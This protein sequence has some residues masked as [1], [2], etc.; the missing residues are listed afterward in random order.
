[1]SLPYR[2]KPLW[3]SKDR[4]RARWHRRRPRRTLFDH[5]S[6]ILLVISACIYA[7]AAPSIGDAMTFSLT[8]ETALAGTSLAR[9]QMLAPIPMKLETI[10]PS[11][12]KLTAERVSA[13]EPGPVPPEIA[14]FRNAPSRKLQ[15]PALPGD[16]ATGWR[17]RVIA[18]AYRF[19][20]VPY[21][22][23]GTDPNGFDCSGLI[24]YVMAR[25]GI[26]L[27]RTMR[28]M[29][30]VLP[31]VPASDLLPGDLVFFRSTDH[32]GI[33]IGEG[34]FLH[35]SSANERRVTISS[36]SSPFYQRRYIGS[37]RIAG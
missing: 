5:P 25:N 37:G 11:W 12:K 16:P 24:Q 29:Y 2:H 15:L 23:G 19:I 7:A 10:E 20:G 14:F 35:A 3:L 36:L 4:A 31:S 18:D 30:L 8:D 22:W 17:G 13:S 33:Y 6:L 9:T 21:K 32:V 1:M 26:Q 34:K 27:P 28:E